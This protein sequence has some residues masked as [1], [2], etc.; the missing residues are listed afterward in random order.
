MRAAEA[1]PVLIQALYLRSSEPWLK[2]RILVALGKIGDNRAVRPVADYLSRESDTATLGTAIFALGE[3]GD[4][5][6]V[7]DL[8]T[9]AERSTDERVQQL[10]RDAIGKINERQ[11]N[12]EVQVKALQDALGDQTQRPA[13]ASAAPPLAY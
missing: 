7:P 6:A 12:P 9:V 8:Q 13:G 1:T 10:A 11:I 3:M 2:Q 4:K 5:N